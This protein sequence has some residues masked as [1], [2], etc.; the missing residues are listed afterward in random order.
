MHKDITALMC[1]TVECAVSDFSC[2]LDFSGIHVTSERL[3]S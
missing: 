1:V 2:R 3:S